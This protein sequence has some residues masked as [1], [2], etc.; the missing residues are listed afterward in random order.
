MKYCFGIDVG[1]TTIKCGLFSEECR[2][3]E[4]WEIATDKSDNGAHI[5]SDIAYAIKDKLTERAIEAKSII[6]VGVGVPGPVINK[7]IVNV[8]VNL[9]WGVVD[10]RGLLMDELLKLFNGRRIP[11]VV[12]NDANIAALGEYAC[13][14]GKG[15]KSLVMVTLGTGVGGGV[16]MDGK[17]FAG[18]NGAAG[19]IGHMP[20]VYDETEYCNC[21]KRGCLEQVASAT[22][23]VRVARKRVSAADTLNKWSGGKALTSKMIFDAMAKGDRQAE[24]VI[25]EVC[26]YLAIALAHITCVINPEAIVI[27]GGVSKAGDVLINKV[28][29]YYKEKAFQGC[30]D[31]AIVLAKLGN[32]AGI[33]GAAQNALNNCN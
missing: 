5:I 3:L 29:Q 13:G 7:S 1:G 32:D 15:Y 18:V 17:V 22:G 26:E 10:V 20:V 8:C 9:G 4:K 11:V 21:G 33:Y 12:E 24:A 31:T 25:N 16:V 14:G 30:K 23:I 19:E 2:L 27:G 6:G 28:S